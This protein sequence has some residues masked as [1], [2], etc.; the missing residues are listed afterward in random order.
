MEWHLACWTKELEFV[1]PQVRLIEERDVDAI[2]RLFRQNYGSGYLATD[3]YDG[4]WVKRCVYGDAVIGAVI[5]DE[6]RV[7]G[8]GALLMNL[9]DHNDRSAEL[10]RLVVDP[11][12][13]GRGLGSRL[14]KAL[15]T[16]ADES[17]DYGESHAR[18]A[19]LHSQ[20]MLEECGFLCIGFLPQYVR[21]EHLLPYA[22]VFSGSAT[23]RRP[24]PPEVIP[25]A[26]PLMQYVLGQLGWSAPV[27]GSLADPWP[28]DDEYSVVG[29]DAR[30]IDALLAFRVGDTSP[31]LLGNISIERGM[32][33][34]RS[35][36][37]T[38]LVALDREGR[39]A[40]ALGMQTDAVA[41]LTRALE[42][43]GDDPRVLGFL[44]R[45]FERRADSPLLEATVA[46]SNPRAQRTLWSLGFRPAAYAPAVSF[47]GS[48]RTDGL[49]MVKIREGWRDV[50][51]SATRLTANGE[52]ALE[53]V[54]AAF[55]A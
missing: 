11:A 2:A 36:K 43:I 7:V 3:V 55:L 19:H 28:T 23:F 31:V 37:A 45:E 42:L 29:L 30:A 5:E 22:R 38:Y 8:T 16:A 32:P 54:R 35:R 51:V 13:A 25:E 17:F 39:P 21:G 53:I 34:L 46:V 9:G 10:A 44:C 4:T 20:H 14:V 12:A 27:N 18:T 15:V 24:M 52:K 50:D 48:C 41:G 33:V 47:Q 26:L 6:R 49:R 40:G 1:D